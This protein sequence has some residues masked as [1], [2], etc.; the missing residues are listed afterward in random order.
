MRFNYERKCFRL[1]GAAKAS[2]PKNNFWQFGSNA[3]SY[4]NRAKQKHDLLCG[5]RHME[6]ISFYFRNGG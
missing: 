2:S 6:Y 4:S 1:C 5:E 3:Q